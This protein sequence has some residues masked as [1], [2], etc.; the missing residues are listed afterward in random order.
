M[1]NPPT[2]DS[3][4]TEL[5]GPAPGPEASASAPV[6]QITAS[7]G[8]VNRLPFG[9]AD[10]E[11]AKTGQAAGFTGLPIVEGVTCGRTPEQ[12]QQELK[13]EVCCIVMKRVAK[14]FQDNGCPVIISPLHPNL[15]S[16]CIPC[17]R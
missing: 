2:F 10:I 17:R 4:V 16:G 9:F 13:Q 3:L 6:T 14:W 8:V 7:S 12:K 1:P 5:L 15:T 11:S